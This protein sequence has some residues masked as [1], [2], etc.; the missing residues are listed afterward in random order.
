MQFVRKIAEQITQSLSGVPTPEVFAIP[1]IKVKISTTYQQFFY[2]SAAR[3][4]RNGF[5]ALRR[6]TTPANLVLKA[7]QVTGFKPKLPEPKV[8]CVSDA[9]TI[10]P[11]VL[12]EQN[13][14]IQEINYSE[15]CLEEIAP[16]RTLNYERFSKLI[17]SVSEN[18]VDLLNMP[19]VSGYC[20]QMANSQEKQLASKGEIVYQ[21]RDK[22][23]S[24]G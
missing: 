11:T 12:V 15:N 13:W 3:V 22:I 10:F 8:H 14:Y 24:I 6:G 9:N 17:P 2:L 5:S 7:A 20:F 18:L 23:G 4:S 1:N 19:F 16:A 21:G